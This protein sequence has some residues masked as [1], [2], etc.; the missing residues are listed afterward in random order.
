[1]K[2]KKGCNMIKAKMLAAL[3]ATSAVLYGGTSAE[4]NITTWSPK[5][6][7][8]NTDV[9]K[10]LCIAGATTLSVTISG[11]T[12]KG[13]DYI[14]V[15]GTKFSGLL[16]KELE[17]SGPCITARFTTDSSVIRGKGPTVS[18]VK[19][20]DN[21]VTWKPEYKEKGTTL[22]SKKLCVPGATGLKVRI[23]GETEEN[24][25]YITLTKVNY[26]W[27]NKSFSGSL[28]VLATV[29]GECISLSF[30]TDS[31]TK[32]G[33][34]PTVTVT[35][36][37]EPYLNKWTPKYTNN[38]DESIDLCYFNFHSKL[39]EG[40]ISVSVT[41]ESEKENDF[42]TINEKYRFS[43]AAD[44]YNELTY[45]LPTSCIRARFKTNGSVIQGKG[46]TVEMSL[47][48]P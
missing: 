29:H 25:D 44:L 18:I 46:L 2:I 31:T 10:K 4:S 7:K 28:N 12:E 21:K 3:V 13:F 8:N 24:H 42:V 27:I 6:N 5:Y 45:Y 40:E 14:Y 32:T 15:N 36:N 30:K 23:T 34:G 39:G 43:G 16:S 1:M 11:E 9:S 17:L 33:D 19:K 35:K 41:G 20:D 38:A 37:E 47:F 26:G 22:V 48:N